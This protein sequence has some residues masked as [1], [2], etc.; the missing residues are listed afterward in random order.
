[1]LAVDLHRLAGDGA[2]V[3]HAVERVREIIRI[4]DDA[5]AHAQAALGRFDQAVDM[6][7]AFRVTHV[8]PREQGQDHQR[9]DALGRRVGVVDSGRRQRDAQRF[10]QRRSIALQIGARDRAMDA[11]EIGGNLA[12]DVAAIKIVEPGLRQM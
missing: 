12:P 10:G 4:G 1:M 7:E 9:H 8:Q 11:F 2:V 5:V 3:E 6:I